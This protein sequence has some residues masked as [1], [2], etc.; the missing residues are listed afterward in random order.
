MP[1][2]ILSVEVVTEV[3]DGSREEM[4]AVSKDIVASINAS[5]N[6]N[7][8]VEDISVT[9]VSVNVPA[10]NYIIDINEEISGLVQ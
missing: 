7:Q 1:K 3:A 5:V 10:I 8:N 9:Q 2:R 4:E 6:Q